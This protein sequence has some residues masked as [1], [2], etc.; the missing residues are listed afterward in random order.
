MIAKAMSVVKVV[1]DHWSLKCQKGMMKMPYCKRRR[2]ICEQQQPAGSGKVSL[3]SQIKFHKL[4]SLISCQGQ[5][6]LKASEGHQVQQI[7]WV[8]RPQKKA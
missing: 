1:S 4:L 5:L 3:R 8:S 2:Q 7:P 6:Y